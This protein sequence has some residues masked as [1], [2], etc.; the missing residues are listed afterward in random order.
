MVFKLNRY[1]KARLKFSIVSLAIYIAGVILFSVWNF[2]YDKKL[3]LKKIDNQLYSAA[4]NVKYLL[5]SSFFESAVDSGKINNRTDWQNIGI[6]TRY[7]HSV[8]I[9]FIY[10]LIKK[11]G[12]IYFT[13]CS[14]NL[15][16]LNT[17]NYVKYWDPYPE[18]SKD[19]FRSI[20]NNKAIYGTSDDH[21]GKFR[22]VFIP[23]KT[24]SGNITVLAA[25]YKYQKIN[26]TIITSTKNAIFKGF[27]FILLAFPMIFSIYFLQRKSSKYLEKKIKERTEELTEEINERKKIEEA[28]KSSYHQLEEMAVKANSASQAKSSFLAT[29]S[30]EIRTPMNGIIGMIEILKQSDLSTE[31]KD[32]L[33]IIDFSA[34]N[35]LAIVND[36]LDFSKIESGQIEYEFIPF[37][38]SKSIEDIIKLLSFKTTDKNISLKFEIDSDVPHFIIGDQV[39][40]NQI[41]LNLTNNAIKFTEKGSVK[42]H[43]SKIGSDDTF[44]ELKFM[45]IDTGIGISTEGRS[46]LFKEFSQVHNYNTNKFGGTGLGLAISKKLAEQMGG[47]IGVESKLGKGSSFWFTI[48]VKS[49]TKETY[50]QSIN[51]PI[52]KKM[53]QILEILVAEDNVINQKIVTA[54]LKKMG[55]KV[56]LANNGKIAVEMFKEKSFDMILMDVQM[57]EMNGIEATQIIRIIE[58][59]ENKKPIFIVAMTANVL[60]EDI[61]HYIKIGM[62][63]Y[64]SKPFKIEELVKLLNQVQK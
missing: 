30:H 11:D 13:S 10:T 9:D 43:L 58:E 7:A 35:L 3:L 57:P 56:T 64:L 28:L 62:N 63:A 18:A 38:I 17:S 48:K 19:I 59:N 37:N 14:T 16:E 25:D 50:L 31:Q 27:F 47:K 55:H 1:R 21:W 41:I 49:S 6:L 8:H 32:S 20:E 36:I 12:K 52:I 60:K 29:M 45:I 51:K 4:S 5:P 34:N 15:D 40:I 24:K 61:E 33:N 39:R 54:N 2:R 22:S 44:I 42:I 23:F 26:Q 46:K 53:E